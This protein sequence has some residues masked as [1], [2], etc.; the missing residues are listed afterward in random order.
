MLKIRVFRIKY[1]F[2]YFLLVSQ[3]SKIT[4]SQAKK[5]LSNFGIHTIYFQSVLIEVSWQWQWGRLHSYNNNMI[6][7][8]VIDICCLILRKKRLS[9]NDKSK[10]ML[11]VSRHIQVWP[12]K[13]EKKVRVFKSSSR[14]PKW[15]FQVNVHCELCPNVR[16]KADPSITNH[17][18]K[19][20][21]P[22]LRCHLWTHSN[23]N[24]SQ[25][26]CLH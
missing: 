13:I 16:Y 2:K 26:T 11:M 1:N 23:N 24:Q 3:L 4:A 8:E 22:D 21:N 15:N 12:L 25:Q 6:C 14:G 10:R 17:E 19:L 20:T 5:L 7:N 9:Q 18:M